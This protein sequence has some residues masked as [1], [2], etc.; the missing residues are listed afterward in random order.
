MMCAPPEVHR[1][2]LEVV[3]KKEH[4]MRT[5]DVEDVLI[6]SVLNT[7]EY[8]RKCVPLWGTQ[9]LRH[10]KR[11]AVWRDNINT[12]N[13]SINVAKL[14]L[15]PEARS[16]QDR[17]DSPIDSSTTSLLP[18]LGRNVLLQRPEE[19]KLIR[20][21]IE[22]FGGRS[23]NRASLQEEQERELAPEAE[24]ER[25]VERTPSRKPARHSLHDELRQMVTSGHLKSTSTAFIPAFKALE[26]TGAA[27]R[28]DL[29][30]W[31]SALLAT[32]DFARTTQSDKAQRQD[33][34][35]RS[36]QWILACRNSGILVILSPYEANELLPLLRD[37]KTMALHVY[38][39][40]TSASMLPLDSLRFCPVPTL[41]S[42]SWPNP[43]ENQ[44]Q[45]LNLFAGQLY[46]KNMTEYH[47]MCN[48]LGLCS[49]PPNDQVDVASDGFV[50]P[51]DREKYDKDM[52]KICR[53]HKSPVDMLRLLVELRRKGQSFDK[54]HMGAILGGQLL[55]ERHFA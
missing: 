28:F 13:P 48:F 20:E 53:F 15:E 40:R 22:A 25:Q 38:S 2:I 49:R 36:V 4:G 43:I 17:Y 18:D 3:E 1:N 16:M 54:S 7:Q 46:L 52:F 47:A 33:D 29:N 35:L 30:T 41:A 32:V 8:M 19:V 24:Q 55:K 45:Q 39:A 34:F 37:Q 50:A 11:N 6:W 27:V 23:L 51:K 12:R 10:Q 26:N 14:V 42:Q 31:P 9:G 5:L 21:K 44:I